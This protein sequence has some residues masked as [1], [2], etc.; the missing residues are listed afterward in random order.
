MAFIFTFRNTCKKIGTQ[1][2]LLFG[3]IGKITT[4]I[5]RK[6]LSDSV[7]I[8]KNSILRS[9]LSQIGPKNRLT[10]QRG[11]TKIW[12]GHIIFTLQVH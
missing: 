6:H 2:F 4:I 7:E 9:C 10:G 8:K 1:F 5:K 3:T 11:A 12:S